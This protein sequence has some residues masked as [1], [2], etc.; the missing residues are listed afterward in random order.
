MTQ[1]LLI[2]TTARNEGPFL[3]EWLAHHI[4]A[5][6][7]DI[8][9][10]SNDCADGTDALLDA[11]AAAG[12]LTHVAHQ[13]PAG[14]S[15]QW[16]A[17]RAAWAHPLRK[18]ADW[19]LG[20]DLDEFVNIHVSGH[21]FADLIAALPQGTDAIALPWR[22]FGDNGVY[23]FADRPVTTQFTAAMAP[24]CGY[25]VSATFFKSLFRSAGPFERLGVHRP[26]HKPGARPVW[27]DGSGTPLPSAI[28]A[29]PARLSLMGREGARGLA[30]IN[31]YAVKS[32][33]SFMLKRARGLPNRA[34][35]PVDLAYWVERNFNTVEDRS[36]AAMAP[37]TAAALARLRAIPGVPAL[38]EAAVAWHRAAFQRVVA[39]PVEH[40]L[41]A[42]L[43]LAGGSRSIAP[44]LRA[45]VFAGYHRALRA[46]AAG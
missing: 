11:L 25:P 4:G 33:E 17:L 37:A 46:A 31:H 13:A 16:Q 43:L 21:R 41:Y 1:R 22:F 24:D 5:G 40:A 6:A 18:A 27:V 12:V 8:L 39:E 45:H 2:V 30:E 28:A 42:H 32:A 20:I 26:R 14:Q 7:S 35:K 3:L 23:G 10:Y 15:V 9:V 34:S 44:D 29:D 38:H 36:I 19:V